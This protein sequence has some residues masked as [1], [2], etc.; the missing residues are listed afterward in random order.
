MEEQT[1]Q[2][3]IKTTFIYAVTESSKFTVDEV[4]EIVTTISSTQ[5]S[6]KMA[7]S[8]LKSIGGAADEDT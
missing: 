5:K 8:I 3:K 2:E 6:D 4:N 1:I 7:E